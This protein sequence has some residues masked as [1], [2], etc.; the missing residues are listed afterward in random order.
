[1][2]AHLSI[3]FLRAHPFEC[4]PENPLFPS[5][6]VAVEVGFAHIASSRCEFDSLFDA[7]D[8]LDAMLLLLLQEAGQCP[9][10][11]LIAVQH[12]GTSKHCCKGLGILESHG[13]SLTSGRWYSMR[14]VA[15]ED[16]T[17]MT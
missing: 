2:R 7:L 5:S 1:M 9:T 12:K 10:I 8:A 14:C 3:A 13:R 17:I 4:K 15:S 6:V 11:S 16:N